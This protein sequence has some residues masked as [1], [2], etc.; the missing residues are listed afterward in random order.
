M[1][2]LAL[3]AL[4]LASVAAQLLP[5]VAEAHGLFALILAGEARR[6][7]R[8]DASG[9]FVAI[10]EQDIALWDFRMIA[11]CHTALRRAAAL[12]SPGRFQIEAAIQCVHLDRAK[13]GRTDWQAIVELYKSLVHHTAAIGARLGLSAALAEAG[14]AGEAA[15]VLEALPAD[16]VAA[17]QPY[18]AV[19]AE[20]CARLGHGME[21]AQAYRRAIEL[22]D[23]PATQ[24]FLSER[25]SAL[26]I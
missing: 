9:A 5:Q 11:D 26:E 15:F 14:R 21:A 4:W 24:R 23:D 10:G 13:T 19:R 12:N 25:L 18:W 7:A 2:G 16:R 6:K 17:H 8:R 1:S 3:E 22:S 20:I